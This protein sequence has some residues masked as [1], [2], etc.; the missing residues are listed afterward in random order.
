MAGNT[1]VRKRRRFFV[2]AAFAEQVDLSGKRFLVTGAS[3]RSLGFE[4]AVAL[5]SW[6]ARVVVTTRKDAELAAGE[7]AARIGAGARDR[8][9]GRTLDLC[10]P[11]SVARFAQW[12]ADSEGGV[13]D[14]L[15]NNAGVH[16]DLMSEWK[17][18]HLTDDGFEVHWR[19]NYLGTSHLTHLFLPAIRRA[20]EQSGEAR[21]VNVVSRLHF[22][23]SNAELFDGPDPYDSWRAYG[24]SKLGLVHATFEAQRRFGSEF[25]VQSYCL[26]PG[27]TV[28]SIAG[29]GLGGTFAGRVAQALEPLQKLFLKSPEEGAQTQIHCATAPGIA[30]GLYYDD[31]A[32]AEVSAESQDLAVAERLWVQTEHWVDSLV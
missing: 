14:V 25:G 12:Y 23:S 22:R 24:R 10:D 20:A 15:I 30:G 31:C 4:T 11:S 8:V 21:I 13:L 28:T 7:V 9:T 17:Q 3:P 27:G 16:F 6:G 5:A 26:H 29:K 18:P 1:S 2:N 32:P 19:T